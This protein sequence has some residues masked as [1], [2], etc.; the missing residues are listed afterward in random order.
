MV[1][2]D[3]YEFPTTPTQQAMWF[4]H[5]ME[6]NGSAYN[7]PLAFRLRGAL[8]ESALRAAFEAL[9]ARH[10]ILRTLFVEREGL[11][12]QRVLPSAALAWRVERLPAADIEAVGRERAARFVAEP[13]DL[14]RGPLLRVQLDRYGDADAVLSIALHHIIIDH[15]SLGQLMRELELLY[16]DGPGALP[17]QVLQFADYTVWLKEHMAQPEMAQKLELWKQRLR[18]FSGVLDLPTDLPRPAVQSGNGAELRFELPIALAEQVRQYAR[19][20]GVSLFIVMLSALKVLLQRYSGQNDIIVGTP[21]ANRGDQE[22]LEQVVGCFINT[23]PIA[24]KFD[25][26]GDFRQL[27]D[28]VKGAMLDAFSAQDVAL[29]AIVEAVRPRRDPSYN[30]LFQVGFVLQEPPVALQLAG[31]AIDELP[32]H[33]GGAMYDLHFWAWEQSSAI[34]GLVWFNSDLYRPETIRRM[35]GHYQRAL[36]VL[37]SQPALPLS[38]VNLLTDDERAQLASWNDT[39]RQWPPAASLVELVRAQALR[40]PDQLAV[41][42]AT[43]RYTFAELEQRSDQLAHHLLAL[44]AGPGQLI[45]IALDRDADLLVGVLGILKCGAAYVPLDPDY[46]NERL[47]YML[48]QADVRLLV[49]QQALQDELPE[50]D[51]ER[52]LLD[53]DWSTI[54]A[55]EARPLPVPE[56]TARMYVIFTSGSTGKPKGVQVPHGCV[57]NFLN[58]MAERPGFTSGQRLLA[59]TTLSFDIAVLELYLPLVCGGTVVLAGREQVGDGAQLAALLEREAVDVMQATPSTWRLL[60]S[61]GWQPQRPFKGLLGGEALP[62]DLVQQLCSLG[63]EAWNMY[64]PTETTV[65]S[66]CHPLAADAPI[67][68]GRPIANT[69][70]HVLDPWQ[71]PLPVGVPGEL[72]IGGDGVTLG[73][74]GRDDLTAE[75]FIANPFGSGRLYRTGDQVRFKPDGNLEYLNR[76]DNQVKVRGFR[77]ELG[78]IEAVLAR[79]PA[80][81]EVA[82][83]AR[84]YSAL[85]KR[86]VAY[87]RYAAGG[88]LTSTELRRYLRE[89]LPDY[90]IPQL[91]VEVDAMPLTPNGKIDRKALPDPLRGDRQSQEVVEPR[92]E[93]ERQLAAIWRQVL[94]VESIGVDNNFFE[95]GGHSLLAMQV[96]YQVEQAFGVRLHVRDLIL[97]SLEQLAATLPTLE[98]MEPVAD[99]TVLA[100]ETPRPGMLG[101]LKRKLGLV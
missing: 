25:G 26:V 37:T 4:I 82:V 81:A 54:V 22:E 42:G 33:S 23:L 90:M 50:H 19:D 7:I 83:M 95:I 86:L 70:C 34:A 44:G 98:V 49:S 71:Q 27:L 30:P 55:A 72:Y 38:Q 8:D 67:Y 21:F 69:T 45:G 11:P 78:E 12:M 73:Y 89:F 64:G 88:Q 47:K 58:T 91:L 68:I 79:H 66:T 43:Q 36:A 9:I 60:L 96:I 15:L 20:A 94:G 46:P 32:V 84:E 39:A 77:I 56:A 61:A 35:L 99:A 80:V 52:V 65:W 6:P 93:A 13:F 51:C 63:V 31:I 87:V 41:I 53:R 57:I 74:L 10:E 101:R 62:G 59:V 100:G 16:R 18:G 3:I 40:T 75:R 1:S 24:T 2:S 14:E 97:N 17:E 76:I 85:D 48:E 29:E 92:T 28:A 5:R